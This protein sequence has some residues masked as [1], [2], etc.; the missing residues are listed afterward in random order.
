M[1]CFCAACRVLPTYLYGLTIS[2]D[3]LGTTI[4]LEHRLLVP[5]HSSEPILAVNGVKVGERLG[6]AGFGVHER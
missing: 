3:Y 4:D 6:L 2:Q 5:S 1:P